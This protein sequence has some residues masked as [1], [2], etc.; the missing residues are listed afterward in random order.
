MSVKVLEEKSKV[1]ANSNKA[2]VIVTSDKPEPHQAIEELRSQAAVQ[3]A[4]AW[5]MSK[6][7]SCGRDNIGAPYPVAAD[8]TAMNPFTDLK[9]TTAASYEIELVFNRRI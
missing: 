8:G 3:V 5:A 7:G 6:L 1:A 2:T 9:T 4:E